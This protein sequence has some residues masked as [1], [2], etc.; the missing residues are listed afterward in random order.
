LNLKICVFHLAG[1]KQSYGD[2]QDLTEIVRE[3]LKEKKPIA[4]KT[5][6]KATEPEKTSSDPDKT[7]SN[8]D[9]KKRSK[10]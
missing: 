10:I 1:T 2:P 7:E 4:D 3:A 8:E 6:D 5:I 9:V